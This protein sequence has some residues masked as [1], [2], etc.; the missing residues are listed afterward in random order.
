M[1]GKRSSRRSLIRNA[2]NGSMQHG[3]PLSLKML[4][5]KLIG[6]H[7]FAP[8]LPPRHYSKFVAAGYYTIEQR[9]KKYRIVFL[10]T[11]LWLNPVDSRMLHRTGSSAV[12]NT[13]DPFGQWSWFQSVLENARKKKETVGCYTTIYD[14]IGPPSGL[15][16]R[17]IPHAGRSHYFLSVASRSLSPPIYTT[18]TD[19][20]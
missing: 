12:D 10:N 7:K 15:L 9:S 2:R 1:I 17:V 14:I 20:K 8:A 13:Q 11:N 5:S 16:Y 4:Q 19:N 6:G 18:M 3:C